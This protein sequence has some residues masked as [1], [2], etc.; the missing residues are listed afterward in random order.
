MNKDNTIVDFIRRFYTLR[1]KGIEPGKEFLNF[2]KQLQLYLGVNFQKFFSSN[3]SFR[4]TSQDNLHDNYVNSME[5]KRDIIKE[6]S[7]NFYSDLY[8]SFDKE[9][10]LFWEETLIPNDENNSRLFKYLETMLK[11]AARKFYQSDNDNI[12]IRLKKNITDVIEILIQEGYLEKSG[13][14]LKKNGALECGVVESIRFHSR[15]FWSE[16]FT[17]NTKKL[18]TYLKEIFDE[19]LE[20]KKITISSLVKNISEA[21][22]YGDI[23]T[24]SLDESFEQGLSKNF[25]DDDDFSN[26]NGLETEFSEKFTYNYLDEIDSNFIDELLIKAEKALKNKFELHCKVFYFKC[27]EKTDVQISKLLNSE[28]GKSSVKNYFEK[29][30][31]VIGFRKI[32]GDFDDD[33]RSKIIEKLVEIIEKKYPELKNEVN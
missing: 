19:Y 12:F 8:S 17:I 30:I 27:T 15:V 4:I 31:D 32:K 10:T 5:M 20:N 24:F 28:I 25:D 23:K 18:K 33:D 11:S 16:K 3:S 14:F 2:E 13:D 7:Q 9:Q 22:N 26:E 6:I 1:K 29:F 21:C